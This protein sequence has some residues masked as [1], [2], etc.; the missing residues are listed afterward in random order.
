MRRLLGSVRWLTTWTMVHRL[1]LLVHPDTWTWRCSL[2]SSSRRW[3]LAALV[4]TCRR[5]TWFALGTRLLRP[6]WTR[7]RPCLCRQ[8]G[9]WRHLTEHR[10]VL[11]LPSNYLVHLLFRRP[12]PCYWIGAKRHRSGSSSRLAGRQKSW[13]HRA[14]HMRFVCIHRETACRLSRI[15]MVSF[16]NMK[17]NNQNI[18][19]AFNTY[20]ALFFAITSS[21]SSSWLIMPPPSLKIFSS[22]AASYSAV[23]HSYIL[24]PLLNSILSLIS[25][26]LYAR[27]PPATAA[28]ANLELRVS[29]CFWL[30]P[31][32]LNRLVTL[33]FND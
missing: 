26:L 25:W 33:M 13:G 16:S 9:I 6:D 30:R 17:I 23:A 15:E 7:Q 22:S 18:D 5:R 29:L 8:R 24:P 2:S 19:S 4:D 10:L 27:A 28:V 21:M 14:P 20:I 32:G 11:K 31:L 1:L 12:L 3:P